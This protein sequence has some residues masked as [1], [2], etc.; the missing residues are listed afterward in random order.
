[1]M[2]HYSDLT[3]EQYLL[4]ELPPERKREIDGRLD[5]DPELRRRLEALKHTTNDI[6][7]A[8]P[9]REMAQRIKDRW[10]AFSSRRR[11][12]P[13]PWLLPSLVAG[14]AVLLLALPSLQPVFFQL[15]EGTRIKGQA[16]QLYLYRRVGDQVQLLKNNDS[17]Q[18]GDLLQIAYMSSRDAF[19]IILSLDGRGNVT[20]HFPS[21]PAA[22]TKLSRPNKTLLPNAYELDDAPGYERFFFLTSASALDV[23]MVLQAARQLAQDQANAPAGFLPVAAKIKQYSVRI[24][25]GE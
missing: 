11:L 18:K 10:A 22:S 2:P 20:L 17:G 16:A 15:S 8:Y 21:D 12:R 13:L 14:A 25:K 24:D 9:P 3:L 5:N 6:L 1:M 4:N 7:A 19:G 23:N